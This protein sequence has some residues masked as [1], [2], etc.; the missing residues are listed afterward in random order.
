MGSPNDAQ[1]QVYRQ[2]ILMVILASIG[3]AKYK[4]RGIIEL[5]RHSKTSQ[6]IRRVPALR[7]PHFNGPFT[8]MC[9]HWHAIGEKRCAEHGQ[10]PV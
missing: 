7:M 10:P 4:A 8:P 9:P 2:R 1:Q 6:D 5:G 3:I